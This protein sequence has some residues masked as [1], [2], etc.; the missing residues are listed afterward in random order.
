MTTMVLIDI[1]GDILLPLPI[2]NK[3]QISSLG[4]VK[5]A[6]YLIVELFSIVLGWFYAS[7][8]LISWA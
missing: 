3:T 7:C 6:L 5:F 1:S 8:T 2:I 4:I